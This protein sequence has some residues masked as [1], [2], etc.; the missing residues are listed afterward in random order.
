[1]GDSALQVFDNL[2]R[3]NPENVTYRYH[4]A[5]AL[6]QKGEKTKAKAELQ[7]ALTKKP[8]TEEEQKIRAALARIG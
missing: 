3:K 8:P 1:M 6:L 2:V 4:L 5:M 7:T